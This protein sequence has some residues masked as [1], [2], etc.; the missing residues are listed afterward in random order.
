M[1]Q[2]ICPELELSLPG[3]RLVG[4][5]ARASLAP[6]QPPRPDTNNGP[7]HS[8]A[9]CI[10]RSLF[11]RIVALSIVASLFSLLCC[12][13]SLLTIFNCFIKWLDIALV[14]HVYDGVLAINSELETNMLRF[15]FAR[16]CCYFLLPSKNFTREQSNFYKYSL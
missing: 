10:T 2:A 12:F 14:Y 15:N 9:F 8:S 1:I 7:S 11:S 3:C 16:N 13:I 5:K 4:F 6:P